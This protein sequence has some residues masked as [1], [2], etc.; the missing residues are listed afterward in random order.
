MFLRLWACRLSKLVNFLLF[1]RMALLIRTIILFFL[2]VLASCS[3]PQFNL[4]FNLKSEITDNYN[5]TYYATDKKGGKT[6]QAVASVRE[7]KCELLGATMQPTLVFLTKRASKLPLVMFAERGQKIEIS[8]SDS[9]P[10]EW[11]VAGNPINEALSG[12]RIS[13]E[14]ILKDCNPDSVNTAV[15]DF[16]VENPGNPVSTILMLCYFFRNNDEREFTDLMYTLEGE[17]KDPVWLRRVGRI[18]QLQHSYSYPARLESLVMK[19]VNKDGDTLRIDG[20]NPVLLALWQTGTSEKGSIIDSLKILEKDYKDTLRILADICVDPDSAAWRTAIR[21]DS[22]NE[23]TK[24]LW[25]PSGLTDPRLVKLKVNSLP[26]FIVF[27]SVG[28]QSFRGKDLA[29]AMEIYRKEM[30][31]RDSLEKANRKK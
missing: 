27:D 21:K 4:E 3:K 13:N 17:A 30:T 1:L 29:K 6:I 23:K 2:V 22:L 19:S 31:E 15:K 10:L 18:D 12:W 28:Q 11:E 8:G 25:A 9:D 24:R 7:G 14:N 26:Y 16:V 5:V 20:K